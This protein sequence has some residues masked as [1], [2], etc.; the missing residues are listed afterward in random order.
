MKSNFAA[1]EGTGESVAVV[2]ID[3]RNPAV[4]G[5]LSA[6]ITPVKVA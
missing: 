2:D 1:A 5:I 3:P 4:A 6:G